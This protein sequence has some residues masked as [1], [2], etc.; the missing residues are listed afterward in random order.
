MLLKLMIGNN[1]SIILE[2]TM[3][4]QLFMEVDIS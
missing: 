2:L 4:V 1:S 3:Q